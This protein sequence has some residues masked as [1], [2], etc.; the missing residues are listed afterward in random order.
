MFPGLTILGFRNLTALQKKIK[1]QIANGEYSAATDS[2]SELETL[3]S[4]RSNK[5]DFYNFLLDSGMDPVAT[6]RQY[7]TYLSS[8]RTPGGGT[9]D[10]DTLMNGPVKKKLK[11]IPKDVTW[12]GQSDDVFSA[13]QGDFMRPRINEVDELLAKGI[14]VT[15]YS[16]QL[17]IICA[18]KG[19]ER[20]LEK[21][22]WEG[23]Q[24]F[25]TMDRT[26]ILCENVRGTRA[27]T[28]SYKNLHLYWVL[29]SGHFVPVDQPCAALKMLGEITE[30]PAADS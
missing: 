6:M 27:F 1:E 29:G 19:T 9:G 15:I 7:S 8:L 11:I 10:L 26:P 5:V 17:D 12:G 18:T 2:W 3:I 21:L 4:Y 28:A 13:F 24:E 23:L 30:S 25:L 22:K 16:G 14:N 20:W